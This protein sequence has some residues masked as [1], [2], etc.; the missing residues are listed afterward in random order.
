MKRVFDFLTGKPSINHV[1]IMEDKTERVYAEYMYN[2]L[3]MLSCRS[4]Y[5]RDDVYSLHG[6][7]VP[8]RDHW[9][10][11]RIISESNELYGVF[12]VK[13]AVSKDR[14]G[15]PVFICRTNIDET[16]LSRLAR[17]IRFF[18]KLYPH[19]RKHIH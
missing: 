11:N 6:I 8:S 2:C 4:T 3:G 9:Y 15:M 19:W 5:G 12:Y 14:C 18:T 16:S 7:T 1:I 10:K 17:N 13:L